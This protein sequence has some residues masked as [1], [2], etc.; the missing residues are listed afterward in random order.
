MQP[1][2]S[3]TTAA[4]TAYGRL[5]GAPAT[6]RRYRASYFDRVRIADGLIVERVQQADV[7]GQ[8]R[9]LYGRGFGAVGLSAMLWHLPAG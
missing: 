9:Q 8:M 7:L 3:S 4:G 5:Y 1:S 6:H 2:P